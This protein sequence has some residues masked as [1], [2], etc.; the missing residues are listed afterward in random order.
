M[1]CLSFDG[2]VNFEKVRKILGFNYCI[3]EN[4]NTTL[5]SL[6]GLKGIEETTQEVIEKVGRGGH[7]LVSSG[8]IC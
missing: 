8:F 7:L 5:S 6:I 4:V 3:M 2:P 1:D